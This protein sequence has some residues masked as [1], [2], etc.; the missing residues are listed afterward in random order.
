MS[1]DGA[2]PGALVT[3]DHHQTGEKINLYAMPPEIDPL[4]YDGFAT[5]MA[6][7]DALASVVAA[8]C[9][10]VSKLP[11]HVRRVLESASFRCDHL[12]AHPDLPEIVD[13]AGHAF[14][15]YVG[16]ALSQVPPSR[17]SAMF[18]R[19]CWQVYAAV[20]AGGTL[21]GRA[22]AGWAE[23]V[24]TV[25][26]AGHLALHGPVLTVDLRKHRRLKVRPDAWYRAHPTCRV[27]ILVDNHVRGG[28]RYT[29]GHNPF[30]APGLDV[31]P[32][33]SVLAA[34]EFAHGPPAL[35]PDAGAGAENWGGRA[36]V[37]GSPWNFGSRLSP[38]VVQE[39]TLA[40]LNAL[41]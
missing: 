39:L 13:A 5:T 4:A 29:L 7:T 40:W 3:Y 41:A 6:D 17:K 11:P 35:R 19:L 32:V 12:T 38:A 24:A 16:H 10:G 36:E 33:L 25:G 1:L 28:I 2:V 21:P 30:N 15:N 9:G 23:A 18:A 31:R 26:R 14:D 27:A 37:G 22:E 8:L 34:A 20:Q